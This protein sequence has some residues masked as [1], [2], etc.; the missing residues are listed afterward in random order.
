[1]HTIGCVCVWEWGLYLA[2]N[3]E[4]GGTLYD[5]KGVATPPPPPPPLYPPLLNTLI[6]HCVN[7]FQGGGFS[8]K[9]M[10][11]KKAF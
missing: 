10:K 7:E 1:M 8:R 9:E 5:D 3:G 2:E 4:G 11:G 6:L